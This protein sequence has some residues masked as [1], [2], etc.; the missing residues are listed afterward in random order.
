M[1]KAFT[2][3]SLKKRILAVLLVI[4]FLFCALSVRLFVIQIINGKTLQ[5]RATDQWTRDLAIVAPRGTIYDRTG[6]ALAVS[7][8]TYNVYVRAREVK[9]PSFT[10][11]KLADIL[12]MSFEKV[13][14][15]VTN[16]SASEVLIKMQI[17]GELAEKI[18]S[19]AQVAIA[20]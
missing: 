9:E 12:N 8:T 18:Y 14:T 6:S 7:Y 2:L 1:Q 17:E 4:S 15:K 5:A 13:Y 20:R 3:Y 16:K 10:A 19:E 11:H